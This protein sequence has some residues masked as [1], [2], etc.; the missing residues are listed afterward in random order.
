MKKIVITFGLIS[1]AL[2]AAFMFAT[3][4]FLEKIG[5]DRG[6]FVGYTSMVLAFILVFFGIRSYR[7]NVGGGAISFGRAFA[8]GIL[9]AVISSVCYVIAWE[10][11]YFNFMPD[12]VDKYAA[13]VI[14]QARA[15]GATAEVIQQKT[16]EMQQFKQMYSNPFFNVAMTFIEPF[17]VGLLITLISALI[18]RKKKRLEPAPASA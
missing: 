9:I 18:L 5:F 1:G 6:L 12:F 13:Q 14:A 11:L 16:Q 7:E 10:I 3:L 17:P 4:P 8:V 2:M 15:S